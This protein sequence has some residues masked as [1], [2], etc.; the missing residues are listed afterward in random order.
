LLA[1]R[2]KWLR[3]FKSLLRMLGEKGRREGKKGGGEGKKK[4]EKKKMLFQINCFLWAGH[5]AA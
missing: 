1:R 5:M 3:V 2:K 4:G